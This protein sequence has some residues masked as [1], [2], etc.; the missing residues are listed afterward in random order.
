[1]TSTSWSPNWALPAGTIIPAQGYLLVW[2]DEDGKAGAGLHAC[3][4]SERVQG[5]TGVL[6]LERHD[7]HQGVAVTP[8]ALNIG[9]PRL[10][11]MIPDAGREKRD[12]VAL[13][14]GK[15]GRVAEQD[16]VVSMQD[17]FTRTT[18]SLPLWV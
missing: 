14:N 1:M 7:D 10:F 15:Q 4:C 17:R 6:L 3:H 16:R 11:Q 9:D 5:V 8:D 12:A 2:A 13:G 18:H